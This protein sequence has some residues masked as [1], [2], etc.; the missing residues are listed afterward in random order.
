MGARWLI[1]GAASALVLYLGLRG[2]GT[3]AGSSA[4]P[5]TVTTVTTE[6]GW[7]IVDPGTGVFSVYTPAGTYALSFRSD[8]GVVVDQNMTVAPDVLAAVLRDLKLSPVGSA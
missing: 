4:P 1:V 8:T 3:G 5:S 7:R 2:Q 6:H